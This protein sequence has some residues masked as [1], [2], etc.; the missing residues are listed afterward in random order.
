MHGPSRSG[1]RRASAVLA[2][3]VALTVL[4][5]GC[6]IQEKKENAE[7]IRRSIEKLAEQRTANAHLTFSMTVI[8]TPRNAGGASVQGLPLLQEGANT[9]EVSALLLLDYGNK[10]AQTSLPAAAPDQAPVPVQIFARD[11]VY[12]R[13]LN[14]SGEG[15]TGGRQWVKLDF[16]DHY[17][18]RENTEG[19]GFGSQSLNP[20]WLVDLV[21]GALMG[22]VEVVGTE[23]VRDVSTTRYRVNF[24][25]DDAFEDVDE[26]EREGFLAAAAM[27][28]IPEKVVKGEVWLDDEGQLRRVRANVRHQR[29]RHE[30]LELHY[31]LDLF[32]FGAAAEIAIPSGEEISEV[33]GLGGIIQATNPLGDLGS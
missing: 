5:S 1:R 33:D 20:A 17:D 14:Q 3:A 8:E 12:Q 19:N 22:S 31:T 13:R 15:T 28:G 2:G 29:D 30:E 26:D 32:D 23:T 9:P 16:G 18:D 7:R 11:V 24:S 21:G 10:L 25:W 4:A 27:M 6:G